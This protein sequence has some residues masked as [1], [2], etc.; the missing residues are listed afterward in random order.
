MCC[1]KN[2]LVQAYSAID[3]RVL[4]S[5]TS[6]N[7]GLSRSIIKVL[8][9]IDFSLCGRELAEAKPKNLSELDFF[10]LHNFLLKQLFHLVSTDSDWQP[11][12]RQGTLL[13]NLF[14]LGLVRM[15]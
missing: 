3:P 9:A 1:H 6:M 14:M 13:D 4:V 5:L 7:D 15:I 10:V 11:D 12:E 2:R 8:A